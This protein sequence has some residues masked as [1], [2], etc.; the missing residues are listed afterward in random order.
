MPQLNAAA[1]IYMEKPS[2]WYDL[3]KCIQE[4]TEAAHSARLA[5]DIL[6]AILMQTRINMPDVYH[7]TRGAEHSAYLAW[8]EIERIYRELTNALTR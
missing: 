4:L 7:A 5:W 3:P 8:Q 2:A 6:E 1:S